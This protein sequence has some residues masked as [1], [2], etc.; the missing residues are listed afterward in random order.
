MQK[1]PTLLSHDRKIIKAYNA[2]SFLTGRLVKIKNS[3]TFYWLK[4]YEVRI[5]VDVGQKKS[6]NTLY[7]ANWQAL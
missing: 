4:N 5:L 7:R 2:I 6:S 3:I 1:Y